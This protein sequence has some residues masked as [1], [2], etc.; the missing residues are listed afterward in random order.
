MVGLEGSRGVA[1]RPQRGS[2][3]Q[4]VASLGGNYKGFGFASG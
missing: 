1:V 3:D 4:T 2:G